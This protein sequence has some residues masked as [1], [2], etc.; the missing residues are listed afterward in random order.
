MLKRLIL[1]AIVSIISFGAVCHRQQDQNSSFGSIEGIVTDS[2]TG[3]P[4]M[5]V[6]IMIKDTS[7]GAMTDSKG[8][9][10]IE[11]LRTGSYVILTGL[12][13]YQKVTVPDVRVSTG[14]ATILNIKLP[15][16]ARD[17]W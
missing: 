16:Q 2:E 12:V 7:L 8:M 5:G 6:A 3:K 4:L 10:R 14:K 9:Y 17:M 1:I 11:R 13:Q 15:P